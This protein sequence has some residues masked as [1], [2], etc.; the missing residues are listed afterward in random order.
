MDSLNLIAYRVIKLLTWLQDGPLTVDA[1]NMRYLRDP[2]TGKKLSADTICLYINTLR[3]IGCEITRPSRKNGF[4]YE[5]IYHP[6]G[7]FV[8]ETELNALS[9]IKGLAEEQFSLKEFLAL[10]QLLKNLLQ[11]CTLPER[12]YGIQ[13]LFSINRTIDYESDLPKIQELETWIAEEQLL[14]ITYDSPVKGKER[15]YFLPNRM[16]YHHGVLY[17]HGSQKARPEPICL[18]LDRLL[19]I[20]PIPSPDAAELALLEV[21]KQQNQGVV[22]NVVLRFWG[23]TADE[24]DPMQLG[25][26]ATLEEIPSPRCLEVKLNTCDFFRLKQKLLSCGRPFNVL[27]PE[28]FKKDLIDCLS[29]MEKLYA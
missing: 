16:E 10:Q 12:D 17:V 5:L 2:L 22:P 20:E 21:L 3:K 4:S 18:R 9:Q 28:F 6:F 19:K 1:L 11:Q 13:K 14:W 8:S 7:L 24:F 27:E 23:I 25:E 29:M 15:F 26:P